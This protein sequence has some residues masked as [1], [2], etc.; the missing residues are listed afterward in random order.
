[1]SLV[2]A[3][4]K[5]AT[6]VG[7][8]GSAIGAGLQAGTATLDKQRQALQTEEGV[9]QKAQ[10]LYQQAKMHLDQYQ[11]KTP[12]ELA[13]EQHQ[14]QQLAMSKYQQT[15]YVDENGNYRV[16]VFDT[17]RGMLIDPQTRQPIDAGRIVSRGSNPET[18]ITA[19]AKFYRDA[20]PGM[21]ADE[22]MA[23]ARAEVGPAQPQNK[24]TA[25]IDGSS[26][27]TAIPDP[28][29]G[30]RQKGMWYIGPSGKPQQWL[31]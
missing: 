26:A 4:A 5:M 10:Q 14:A 2:N 18:T 17:K 23:K 25:T 7:P 19:R 8:I 6:T 28:G 12:H 20:N 21:S 31:G 13:T 11:R 3:G 22:A 29:D 27:S 24:A 9:N 30:L 1:M 16:G 15:N